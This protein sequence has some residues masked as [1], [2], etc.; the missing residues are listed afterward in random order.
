MICAGER[1]LRRAMDGVLDL[2]RLLGRVALDSAGP[3][4]VVALGATMARV[5]QACVAAAH[6]ACSFFPGKSMVP[7][8][9]LSFD[10]LDGSVY[11]LIWADSWSEEPPVALRGWWSD[12]RRAGL[13][14]ELDEL[15]GLSSG[16]GVKWLLVT[17]EER[18][19]ATHRH[20]IAEGA[21][22][23]R[24]LGITSK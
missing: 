23:I 5:C 17:I 6:G 21:G 9:R 11:E 2:E 16:T 13:D 8:W 10:T 15:R 4:E 19:R 3:R 22:S 1:G 20:R 24:C 7:S 14:A 12:P 18:E